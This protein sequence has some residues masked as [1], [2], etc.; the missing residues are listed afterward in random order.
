[1]HMYWQP[2]LIA[3]KAAMGM[4]MCSC[5]CRVLAAPL[6]AH[7]GLSLC[8]RHSENQQ[9][10]GLLEV[11]YILALVPCISTAPPV[12]LHTCPSTGCAQATLHFHRVSTSLPSGMLA[13]QAGCT[14]SAPQGVCAHAL[15]RSSMACLGAGPL[16][17]TG[18]K[19]RTDVC[20]PSW[21]RS[22]PLWF[23]F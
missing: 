10:P 18:C 21:L 1:M 17:L 12:E 6:A 13:Q 15:T 11:S 3:R 9:Q 8:C 16:P 7:T 22:I 14:S 19:A 20:I 23:S 2:A 5:R 4:T